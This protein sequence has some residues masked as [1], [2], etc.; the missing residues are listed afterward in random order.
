MKSTDV[1]KAGEPT[2][3]GGHAPF[4]VTQAGRHGNK[5]ERTKAESW[6]NIAGDEVG[7]TCDVGGVTAIREREGSR[8]RLVA[9]LQ[10]V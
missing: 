2:P 5:E 9:W 7:R 6:V 3:I 10:L 4:E 8:A 1:S